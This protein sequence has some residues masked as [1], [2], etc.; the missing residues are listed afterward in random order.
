VAVFPDG[1]NHRVQF[2][3][4]DMLQQYC[5]PVRFRRDKIMEPFIGA[6][7]SPVPFEDFTRRGTLP[8]LSPKGGFFVKYPHTD[9]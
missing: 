1:N 5:V 6:L 7:R 9:P 8:D 4:F 3:L 2:E